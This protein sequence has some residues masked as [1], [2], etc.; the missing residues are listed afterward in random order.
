MTNNKNLISALKEKKR[1]SFFPKFFLD[2]EG[3]FPEGVLFKDISLGF[4][5]DSEKGERTEDVESFR[6]TV[7]DVRTE[8]K[9]V[10][11]VPADSFI[12]EDVMEKKNEPVKFVNLLGG[13]LTKGYWFKADGVEFI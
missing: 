6:V 13:R 5:F 9:I 10:I 8:E 4:G 12:P 3:T 1:D 2:V 11:K 7:M